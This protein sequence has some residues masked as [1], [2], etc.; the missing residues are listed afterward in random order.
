MKTRGVAAAALF[1]LSTGFLAAQSG[2]SGATPAVDKLGPYTLGTTYNALKELTGFR[3]DPGRSKPEEDVRAAK[4]IG[5]NL[6][7]TPTIQRFTFKHDRLIRVSIIF[8]PPAEWPEERV[9]RMVAEQ[10]GE[11]GP[12]QKLGDSSQPIYF[13]KGSIGWLVIL[14]ADGGRWMASCYLAD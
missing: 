5:K 6:F 13:W 12:K 14:P 1:F 8:H 7:N 3:D 11:P 9:K 4:V 2:T 10:W